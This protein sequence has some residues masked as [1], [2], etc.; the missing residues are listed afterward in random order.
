MLDFAQYGVQA[1][2]GMLNASN[3]SVLRGHDHTLDGANQVRPLSL[4][5]S[6]V[7]S[8]IDCFSQILSHLLNVVLAKGLRRAIDGVLLHLLR[9]V[10]ILDYCFS[11]F[12]HG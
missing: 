8:Q 7:T 4:V 5:S 12:R 10:G 6:T 2:T 11:L 3:E 1:G 9:H